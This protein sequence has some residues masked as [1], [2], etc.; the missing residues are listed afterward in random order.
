MATFNKKL[1]EMSHL[2]N[3][4][5][6][7]FR[8]N[9]LTFGTLLTRVRPF[10]RQQN[11]DKHYCTRL[12]PAIQFSK[13][14]RTRAD[15]I[16]VGSSGD[17]GGTDISCNLYSQAV[18]RADSTKLPGR[19]PPCRRD[20]GDPS[21]WIRGIGAQRRCALVFHTILTLFCSVSGEYGCLLFCSSL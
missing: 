12:E 6:F 19:P 18:H 9:P 10:A 15:K 13:V 16:G 20:A 21:R 14:G 3:C 17:M 1:K 4:D 7:R 5:L 2:G 8:N 11:A